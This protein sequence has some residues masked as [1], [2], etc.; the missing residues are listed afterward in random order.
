MATYQEIR[1]HIQAQNG[2]VPKSCWIAHVLAEHGKTRRAAPNRIEP[3]RR[4]H[5]CPPSKRP[6]IEA[7]LRHF[8]MIGPELAYD[9][10]W[11]GL[12]MPLGG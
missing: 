3:T 1:T 10:W 2:F 5:P 11:T 6:A 7:A 4:A 12:D 8:G 9:Q